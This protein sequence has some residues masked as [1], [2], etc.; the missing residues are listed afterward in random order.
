MFVVSSQFL[1]SI[2]WTCNNLDYTSQSQ[3]RRY[4]ARLHY[5]KLKKA[6]ITT[7]CAWRGKVARKELRKLKMVTDLSV[8]PFFFC[9]LLIF[10]CEH[11][12]IFCYEDFF[13]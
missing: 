6:A 9:S 12:W 5:M 10:V 4:L 13:F 7:Q 1:R 11:I 3:C 8:L 2:E